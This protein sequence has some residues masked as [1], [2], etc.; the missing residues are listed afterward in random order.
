MR[1]PRKVDLH[2]AHRKRDA[3]LDQFRMMNALGPQEFRSPAL[4][5]MQIRRV[6]DVPRKIG[7]FVI[8]PDRE[9]MGLSH[10]HARRR[11]C[12]S[13]GQAAGARLRATT[14]ASD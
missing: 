11:R 2:R 7:V 1:R 8:D 12:A 6:I 5:E 3:L 14:W 13:T 9:A 4:E 10:P